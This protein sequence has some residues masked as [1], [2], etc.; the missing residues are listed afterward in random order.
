MFILFFVLSRTHTWQT[1]GLQSVAYLINYHWSSSVRRG[2]GSSFFSVLSFFSIPTEMP[3]AR[4][5]PSDRPGMSSGYEDNLSLSPFPFY[6]LFYVCA[7]AS[8]ALFLTIVCLHYFFVRYVFAG[9]LWSCVFA[10]RWSLIVDE[11][12][13]CFF[14]LCPVISF[15]CYRI[16]ILSWMIA[17]LN[18]FS[19]P[20]PR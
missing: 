16:I 8:L 14:K 5:S 7:R 20:A 2:V 17:R 19:S 13:R 4:F 3:S 15:A 11:G 9:L 6:I 18:N 12:L 1:G 10:F